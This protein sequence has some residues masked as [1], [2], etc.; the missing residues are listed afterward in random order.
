MARPGFVHEVNDRTPELIVHQGTGFRRQEFPLGTQV[1][2]APEPRAGMPTARP[3]IRRALSEP[4]DGTPLA[5]RLRPGMRLAIAVSDTSSVVPPMGAPDVRGVVIE[6]VLNAAAAAG[7]DDVEIIVARGLNRRLDEHELRAVLGDRVLD[8][9]AAEGRIS[10]HDAEDAGKLAEVGTAAGPTAEGSEGEI[11][12][13]INARAAQADLLV[14]VVATSDGRLSGPGFLIHGL[15][16][17][18][19]VRA[20]RGLAG[21]RDGEVAARLGA[22]AAGAVDVFAVEAVLDTNAF[23][24]RLG[25]LNRREWEWSLKDQATL[26]TLRLGQRAVGSRGRERLLQRAA[27]D[28][29]VVSVRAGSPATVGAATVAE[30]D[31]QRL[32]SVDGQADVLITGTGYVSPYGVGSLLNPLLAA[33]LAL[34]T[35]Y[36][37][38]TGTPLVRDGGAMIIFHPATPTFHHRHHPATADFFADVLSDTTDSADMARHEERYAADDW[39]RHLYSDSEA[40]HGLQPFHLWYETEAARAALGDVVWVG[41]DRAVCD[42]MGFRAAST[43][44]DALEIVRAGVGGDPR[45]AYL[46]NPPYALADVTVAP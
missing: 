37:S 1:L 9:F 39:Y 35:A 32:I 15:G 31:Q 23:H 41:G 26:N 36:G 16:S 5:D 46:H 29:R 19:T 42:R 21:Q 40:Y 43:L 22:V 14:T 11:G 2:Y 24:R 25:F 18:A 45:L 13:A 30:V 27:A 12:V 20:D 7:V 3:A 8:A 6:E 4:L 10:Q 17:T 34:G 44:H 33:H 28:T 38:H